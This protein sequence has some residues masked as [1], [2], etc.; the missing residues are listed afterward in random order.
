MD[1]LLLLVHDGV[2]V[3]TVRA[4]TSA[5]RLQ[6]RWPR[7][8]PCQ[9]SCTGRVQV[10]VAAPLEGGGARWVWASVSG[11]FG[12]CAGRCGR[13]AGRRLRDGRTVSGC[14][15][16]SRVVRRARAPPSRRACRRRLAAGGSGTV[17]G[18]R[19]FSLAPLL[20]RYL[21][22]AERDEIAILHAQGV[23]VRGISPSRPCRVDGLEGAAPERIDTQS[24]DR[25]PSDDGAVAR[26]AT[27]EPPEG[28]EAGRERAAARVRAGSARRKDRQAGRRAGARAGRAVWRPTAGSSSG[29]PLGEGVESGADRES[30]P[31]RLPR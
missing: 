16:R 24:R 2:N 20:G 8:A 6:L 18:C 28:L 26:R 22:F 21:S 12:R 3:D 25:V 11:R 10:V 31:G 17:G 4:D 29:S 23:S 5:Q 30:A 13:R 7:P 9:Q 27:R 1:G 15:E 19:Q 14:G